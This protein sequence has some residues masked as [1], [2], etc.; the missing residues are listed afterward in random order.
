MKNKSTLL[1]RTFKALRIN[2]GLS[3]EDIPEIRKRLLDQ[4]KDIKGAIMTETDTAF[5]FNSGQF[6][7]KPVTNKETLGK[8]V[9]GP[10]FARFNNVRV[11]Y[12]NMM[13]DSDFSLIETENSTFA[14]HSEIINS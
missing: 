5:E 6:Y 12:K 7:L 1:G 3:I 2:K 14:L 4:I 10:S 9:F 8:L 13:I 11:E